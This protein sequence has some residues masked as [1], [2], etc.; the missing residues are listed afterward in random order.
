[1]F[2]EQGQLDGIGQYQWQSENVQMGADP[3]VICGLELLDYYLFFV[4]ETTT[5]QAL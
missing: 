3:Q 2:E 1:M 5:T 4:R